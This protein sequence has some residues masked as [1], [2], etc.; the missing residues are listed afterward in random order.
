MDIS[1]PL[2]IFL[3]VL[4]II[5]IVAILIQDIMQKLV[6][7]ILFITLFCISIFLYSQPIEQ[8]IQNIA[9]FTG[10]SFLAKVFLE[11]IFSLRVDKPFK[12][13]DAD[14][15]FIGIISINFT[16]TEFSLF[17]YSTAIL[18]GVYFLIKSKFTNYNSIEVAFI[19]FLLIGFVLVHVVG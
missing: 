11:Y 2:Q 17:M 12:F 15:L 8:S 14:I 7:D 4:F 6:S 19:P 10:I 1:N 13:G 5:N 3:L 9:I 18:W 16:P